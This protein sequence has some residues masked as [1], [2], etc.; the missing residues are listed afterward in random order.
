MIR[1]KLAEITESVE[2]VRAHLPTTY[3][4]FAGLGL[5]KDGIYKRVEY[6][7]ENVFDICAIINTD[8]RLGVPGADEEIIENLVS[9]GVLSRDMQQKLK[10]MRGFRNIVVHRYGRIDDRIA[11]EL[12]QRNLQD[13]EEFRTVIEE[14]LTH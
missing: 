1:I 8:L 11:F 10:A 2:L 5:V 3:D 7:I 4:R 6:A 9:R 13:F 14:F 12:L